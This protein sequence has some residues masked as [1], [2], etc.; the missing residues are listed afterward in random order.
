[1]GERVSLYEL[2]RAELTELV[3]AGGHSPVHA[4]QV[5][6]HLYWD[7]ADSLEKMT[8]LPSR[9]RAQLERETQ[10]GALPAARETRSSDGFSR[11][12]LLGL[13]DGQ[14]IETVL[15]RFTGRRPEEHTSEL[16]S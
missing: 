13:G 7:Y 3:T 14:M 9:V 4:A 11:K 16:Q 10:V 2:T 1:M 12:F 6:R 5:W 15:M 8:G